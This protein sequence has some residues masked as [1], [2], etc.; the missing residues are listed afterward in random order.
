MPLLHVRTR[1]RVMYTSVCVRAC[2]MYARQ[3][4]RARQIAASNQHNPPRLPRT[5]E[6]RFY[7]YFQPEQLR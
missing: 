2:I 7:F 5:K 1:V 4:P 3:Y 6:F